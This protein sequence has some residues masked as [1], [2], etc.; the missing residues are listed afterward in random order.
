[1]LS[2]AKNLGF[3]EWRHWE[4]EMVR[5]AHHDTMRGPLA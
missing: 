3:A 2:A 4:A 1:M 5:F